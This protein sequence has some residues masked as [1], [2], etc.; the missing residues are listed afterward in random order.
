MTAQQDKTAALLFL[1][2]RN[3]LRRV[4]RRIVGCPDQAEDIVQEAFFKF[5]SRD[6]QATVEAP[7]GYLARI[8]RN[9]AI[10]LLRRKQREDRI[11]DNRLDS[12]AVEELVDE[13]SD[14]ESAVVHRDEYRRICDALDELPA[15]MRRAVRMHMIEGAS[16]R[17]IAER[18]GV[19]VGTA[20]SLVK[21][22][23]KHCRR[24]LFGMRS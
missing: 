10:D 16:L 22:G 21:D 23:T 18:L 15:R 17:E 24:R 11:F 20:H 9:L 19:S 7:A 5:A 2:H 12:Q 13:R 4:A 6:Q 8:V 3:E 1:Q 14:P